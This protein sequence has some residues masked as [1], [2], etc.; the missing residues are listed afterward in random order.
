MG[1]LVPIFFVDEIA[2]LS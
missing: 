1:K 2:K